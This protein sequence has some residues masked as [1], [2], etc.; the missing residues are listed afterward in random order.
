MDVERARKFLLSLP[1]AVETMQWGDNLVYWVGDKAIGGK[2]FTLID[3]GEGLSK[4]VAMYSAGP[5]RYAEL[6][7]REG[8]LPAPYMAR[9]HWLAV[10]RWSALRNSEWEDELRGAH[11]ITFAKLPKRTREVLTLPVKQQEKLIAER[12]KLLADK[13]KKPRT[14]KA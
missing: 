1:H 4:G 9:I 13:P 6:L 8:L 12:R 3:L 5:E 2:M 7:E 14:R 11:A 10:E